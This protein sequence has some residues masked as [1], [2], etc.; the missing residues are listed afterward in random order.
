MIYLY[1]ILHSQHSAAV[2]LKSSELVIILHFEI[3][4]RSLK[5]KKNYVYGYMELHLR[6]GV[7]LQQQPR[8]GQPLL[9]PRRCSL[10]EAGMM[11]ITSYIM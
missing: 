6:G 10:W 3:K 2:N 8:N 1:N 7:Q 9:S 11:Y 4:M 5:K